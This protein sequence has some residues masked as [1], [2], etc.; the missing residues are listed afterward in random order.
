MPDKLSINA[1]LTISSL[2]LEGCPAMIWIINH[3]GVIQFIKG[4][5]LSN[6]FILPGDLVGLSIFKVYAEYPAILDK[7]SLALSGKNT[8]A[9]INHGDCYWD[10]QFYPIDGVQNNHYRVIGVSS[11][12]THVL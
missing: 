1:T 6:S 10:C 12:I 11:V 8:R 5:D 4:D 7:V 9:I 3:Q 2:P